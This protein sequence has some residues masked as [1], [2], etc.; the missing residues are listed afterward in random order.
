MKRRAHLI[1]VALVACAIAA[2]C[3]RNLDQQF[4]DQVNDTVHSL[5]MIGDESGLNVH[6]VRSIKQVIIH[7]IAVMPL[8]DAPDQIDKDLPPGA[9]DSVSASLYAQAAVVGGWEV[10]PQDDVG[11]AL[12][13]LPASWL[14]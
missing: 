6:A 11:D 3:N 5:P 1:A 10:V 4:E 12:Q 13:L 9:S 2:G 14:A 7:K 8:V